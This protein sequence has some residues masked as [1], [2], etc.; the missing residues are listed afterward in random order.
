MRKRMIISLVLTMLL[1]VTTVFSVP[2]MSSADKTENTSIEKRL[3]S[4][5]VQEN[6][7]RIQQILRS[8]YL[9]DYCYGRAIA[10]CN[11]EKTK[12]STRS[13]G[14]N[15]AYVTYY[16]NV[17]AQCTVCYR[18]KVLENSSHEC[19]RTHTTCG[20]GTENVCPFRK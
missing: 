13:H 3:N 18:G 20:A 9:C 19:V 12:G 10:T 5:E 17:Y 7:A 11:Q 16:S 8:G 6:E 4:K 15:C 2:V 14:K 1:M